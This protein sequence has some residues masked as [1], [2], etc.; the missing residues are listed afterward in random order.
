[1]L[2]A[3]SSLQANSVPPHASKIANV[4]SK[5]LPQRLMVCSPVSSGVK[6]CHT[7]MVSLKPQLLKTDPVAADVES[8]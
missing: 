8:L 2:G 6:L 4:V 7:S 1:M 5:L 3:V